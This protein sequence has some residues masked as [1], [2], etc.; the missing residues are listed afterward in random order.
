MSFPV[1]SPITTHN[2]ETGYTHPAGATEW[3]RGAAPRVTL[4]RKVR[5][6][7]SRLL[8]RAHRGAVI[9]FLFTRRR[10]AVVVATSNPDVARAETR[11]IPIDRRRSIGIRR[12]RVDDRGRYRSIVNDDD[13]RAVDAEKHAVVFHSNVA[14][15]RASR[16]AGRGRWMMRAGSAPPIAIDDDGLVDPSSSVARRPSSSSFARRDGSIATCDGCARSVVRVERSRDAG[17]IRPVGR[18]GRDTRVEGRVSV[19]C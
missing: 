8:A 16:R 17:P 11:G 9:F 19:V 5:P 3:R 7:A 13:A 14:R 10:I 2:H 15:D 12:P 4:R 6:R 1:V 18:V